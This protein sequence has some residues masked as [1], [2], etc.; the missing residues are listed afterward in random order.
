MQQSYILCY[1]KIRS[2]SNSYL[3]AGFCVMMSCLY[4][5]FV[6]NESQQIR[7]SHFLVLLQ[8][9]SHTIHKTNLTYDK[10]NSISIFIWVYVLFVHLYIYCNLYFLRI[11]S[12]NSF[13]NMLCNVVPPILLL[14]QQTNRT[15]IE[16]C[17]EIPSAKKEYKTLVCSYHRSY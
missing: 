7:Y 11:P 4:V 14:P 8:L 5:C 12:N 1:L 3:R 10:A 17:C 6:I 16:H 15:Y 13:L 2:C 9:Y